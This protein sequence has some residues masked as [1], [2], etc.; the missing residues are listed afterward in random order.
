MA[1]M[2]F[3]TSKRWCC[4][5]RR[6]SDIP[7][8]S[9]NEKAVSD[10]VVQFAKDHGFACHQDDVWNV[11]VDKPAS[12]G[13]EDA[14]PLILQAHMD[15]VN[16]RANDSS[17]DFE[18][19]PLDL[20]VDE[21]GN[22]RARGTTL[23]ADDGVGV[24]Y[25]LAILE[26]DS[27]A[28][29]AL[30]CIF[31]TMEEIGLVGAQQMK[32]SDVHGDRLICLDGGG[33]TK[34]GL[35]SAGGADVN[36]DLDLVLEKN[37]DAAYELKVGGLSGGHSGGE[38]HK[39]KGNADVLAVRILQ[40]ARERGVDVR[41][42]SISGGS[43]DNAIPTDASIVFTS[44]ADEALIQKSL[45]LSV[46]AIHK[47]LEFSDPGFK[48]NIGPVEGVRE[49]ADEKTSHALLDYIYLMPN[50]FQHRSMAI[51]GL[52]LT[53]LNLGIAKTTGNHVHLQTLTR[54][55]LD[56]GVDDLLGKLKK[57]AEILGV[58]YSVSGRYP[59]WNFKKES[60]M[61]DKFAAVLAKRNEKLEVEA[62]H[63][64]NECGVWSGLRPGIDIITFGPITSGCHTVQEKLDLSSFDRSYAIL[65]EIMALC[66]D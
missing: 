15:M 58:N 55:A 27:L 19:D 13:Y 3:D 52:T 21:D 10:M 30:E 46:D 11:T 42:V 20:Y 23:G 65:C 8:G 41:V 14:A 51:E 59:G 57:L 63:G 37:Q 44:S 25:M 35:S 26:D 43:K 18:K 1:V 50:G 56:T 38:I 40:E 66:K 31:T 6:I 47:E 5:F 24:A 28:H 36:L 2:E 45:V 29:P 61:R 60:P 17:H 7:R 22:L 48:A 32:P 16:A 9:R 54:S 53:S 64:G 49:H 12:P 33:E 4:W 34:T 39:E 62:A